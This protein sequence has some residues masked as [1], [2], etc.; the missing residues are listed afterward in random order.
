MCKCKLI[1]V[2]ILYSKP[3]ET[4]LLSRLSQDKCRLVNAEES[5]GRILVDCSGANLDKVRQLL[6]KTESWTGEVKLK[7]L[8]KKCKVVGLCNIGGICLV[9]SRLTLLSGTSSGC[10]VKVCSKTV[11]KL[12]SLILTAIFYTASFDDLK[13]RQENLVNLQGKL[14]CSD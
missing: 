5:I 13:E 2:L 12:V 11:R 1:I 7:C 6:V 14:D 8:S 3:Y 4:A 9:N 10:E